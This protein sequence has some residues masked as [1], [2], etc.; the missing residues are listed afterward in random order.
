MERARLAG[1]ILIIPEDDKPLHQTIQDHSQDAF[2]II[3][4]IPGKRTTGIAKLFSL[5]QFFFTKELE[6]F[7]DLPPLLFVKASR[8]INL[9]GD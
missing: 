2:L 9:M 7:V 6:K 8:V 4:G 5:D 3:M 1:E